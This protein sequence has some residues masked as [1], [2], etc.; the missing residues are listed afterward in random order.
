MKA[1][2]IQPLSVMW[3][4][5]YGECA[6]D[7]RRRSKLLGV[8]KRVDEVEGDGGGDSAAEDEIEHAWPHAFAAQRA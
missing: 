3:S 1:I 2:W 7:A 4:N 8:E 6:I 5:L